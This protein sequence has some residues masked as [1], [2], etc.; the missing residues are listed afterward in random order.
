MGVRQFAV[1]LD[2][3]LVGCH[4]LFRR[5]FHGVEIVDLV[6]LDASPGLKLVRVRLG[7]VRQR[8]V[9]D[10]QPFQVCRGADGL[11]RH[12]PQ[13]GDHFLRGVEGPAHKFIVA[14]HAAHGRNGGSTG[15]ANGLGLLLR[16]CRQ[17]L[18]LL[19]QFGVFRFQR[20][21]FL[22][23]LRGQVMPCDFVDLV[24]PLLVFL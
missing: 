16:D 2:G 15:S 7:F 8:F 3:F 12:Q 13:L 9:G 23:Q 11:S 14:L 24:Q 18:D 17:V 1:G 4:L 6:L 19:F 5:R 10:P 22:D 20:L 21:L